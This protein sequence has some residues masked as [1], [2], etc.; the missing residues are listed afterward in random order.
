MTPDELSLV[1]S[2][3]P[4]GCLLKCW[5]QPRSSRSTIIGIHGDALKIALTAPPVDGKANKE[6]LKFMAKY[7]KLPQRGIQITAGESSR[8]KTILIN[9]L[10]KD[11]II[12][13]FCSE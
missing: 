4:E 8:S 5:I 6:L 13:K 10:N 9:G 11:I 7:F 3:K 1:I 2:E 12:Q